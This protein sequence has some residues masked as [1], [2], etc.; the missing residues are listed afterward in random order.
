MDDLKLLGGMRADAPEPGA[1]RLNALRAR[2]LKRRRFRLAPPLLAMVV[3]AVGIAV[4]VSGIGSPPT[5]GVR[6]L[7]AVTNETKPMRAE[8]VL[9]RAA[10]VSERH[11]PS[12]TPRVDQWLYWK[13]MVRQPDDAA[14]LVEEYWTR[15]DGTQQASRHGQG[16]IEQ[17]HYVPDPN[18]DNLTPREF[19][20]KLAELPTDPDRLLA[21][22]KADRFWMNKA[23]E[24]AGREEHPD[25]R[26]FRV[27]SVY[28]YQEVPVPP[29]LRGA[30]FRALAEI[31]G[32]RV[33]SGVRD[34][35]G[36]AG[37]GIAYEKSASGSILRSDA[38]GQVTS[39]SYLVFDA[40]TY[41]FLGRRVDFLRDE[42]FDGHIITPAGSSYAS[43]VVAAGVVDKPG[44]IP[45]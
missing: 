25:A 26:A 3:G 14:P 39:R 30:I 2:A 37:I 16:A 1:D 23:E 29:R 13:L 35:A 44:D 45:E 27:L 19:A 24:E 43:A 42:V 7:P 4:V 28:L 11:T 40:T 20:A 36:R 10:Q 15:Y 5:P 38:N 22:V 21:H 31:P 33:D 32:V 9:R 12:P 6:L 18:D 34:A 8:I 41:E 17:R